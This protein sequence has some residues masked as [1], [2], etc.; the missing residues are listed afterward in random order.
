[1]NED[2]LARVQ[3]RREFP[4][5]VTQRIQVA[6]QST[7]IGRAL[8]ADQPLEAPLVLR[9]TDWLP[10]LRRLPAR[11]IALGVRPEHVHTPDVLAAT[12]ASGG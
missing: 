6:A 7:V 8:G 1:V 11:L 3:K 10:P 9:L 5:R 2:D 4:T 12:A